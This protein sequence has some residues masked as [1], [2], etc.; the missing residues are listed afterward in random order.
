MVYT[1]GKLTHRCCEERRRMEDEPEAIIILTNLDVAHVQHSGQAGKDTLLSLDK[2]RPLMYETM[3]EKDEQPWT[4][5]TM[6]TK[7]T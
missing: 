7:P 3:T 6:L 2:N 1:V 4:H 5:L